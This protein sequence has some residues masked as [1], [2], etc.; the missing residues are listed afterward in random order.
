MST[1]ALT[2]TREGEIAVITFD[3]PNE[4]VNKF[5]TTV[6]GEWVMKELHDVDEV[7]YVR[8]ASVY[9]D[10]QDV[11]AFFT[12]LKDIFQRRT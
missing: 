6:I 10:F 1:P 4:P 5:S 3:L 12:E 11:E 7:A 2:M 8:F 9:R